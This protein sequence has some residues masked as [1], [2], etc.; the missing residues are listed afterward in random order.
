VPATDGVPARKSG[1]AG[2]A[3]DIDCPAVVVAVPS[4]ISTS[5]ISDEGKSSAGGDDMVKCRRVNWKRLSRCTVTGWANATRRVNFEF[6]AGHQSRANF[7]G[8]SLSL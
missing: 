6:R 2:G 5:S 7:D 8:P 4:P 1:S 3:C